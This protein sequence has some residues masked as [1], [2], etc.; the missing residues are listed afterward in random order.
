MFEEWYI[1]NLLYNLQF[2]IQHVPSSNT[3]FI[4]LANEYFKFLYNNGIN[5][6]KFDFLSNEI[7]TNSGILLE[8]ICLKEGWGDIN[9]Y[10]KNQKQN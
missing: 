9:F 8:Y 4:P 6:Q 7:Y 5:L 3:Q 10:F 1:K 2:F